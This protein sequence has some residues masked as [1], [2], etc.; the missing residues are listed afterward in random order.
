[1]LVELTLFE[2]TN[3]TNK[4]DIAL[5]DDITMSDYLPQLLLILEVESQIANEDVYYEIQ[6]AGPELN[7]QVIPMNQCLKDLSVIGGG[8]IRI[9]TKIKQQPE[10]ESELSEEE[11]KVKEKKLKKAKANESFGKAIK[12]LILRSK[13]KNKEASQSAEEQNNKPVDEQATDPILTK[14]KRSANNPIEINV[15][16][17]NV[18]HGPLLIGLC[19]SDTEVD[20]SNCVFLLASSLVKLG[21]RPLVCAESSHEIE[22][23]E[24]M[25]FEGEKEDTS[26]ELFDFEGVDYMRPHAEWNF[27]DL[28]ESD[29]THVIFWYQAFTVVPEKEREVDWTRTHMP[30]LVANGA[31][32]KIDRL[33]TLLQELGSQERKRTRLVLQQSKVDVANELQKEFTDATITILP[34]CADPLY[35]DVQ[36]V[37][38]VSH[39]FSI[40]KRFHVRRTGFVI[41]VLIAAV[42]TILAISIGLLIRVPG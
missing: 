25:I 16:S 22:S 8:Y 21:Y 19:G 38:W 30:L 1:M 39:F 41:F 26:S 40:K 14:V 23:I 12:D 6:V 32:W 36:T 5:E 42:I 7:W 18:L 24:R 3:E 35:P 15:N 28:M 17:S 29:Y 27:H 31:R 34:N 37:Q 4:M 33:H 11:K 2:E 10:V 20:V 13:N 9:S